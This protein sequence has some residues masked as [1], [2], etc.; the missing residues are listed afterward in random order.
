MFISRRSQSSGCVCGV[1]YWLYTGC[2]LIPLISFD[3][4]KQLALLAEQRATVTA[5]VPTM[6]VATIAAEVWPRAQAA[7][8]CP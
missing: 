6:L 1:V 2:T 3:P 8:L 5:N 7:I 4:L